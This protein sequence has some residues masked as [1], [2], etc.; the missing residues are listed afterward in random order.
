MTPGADVFFTAPTRRVKAL[1]SEVQDRPAYQHRSSVARLRAPGWRAASSEFSARD[2]GSPMA[3]RVRAQGWRVS[4]SGPS[5]CDA[6]PWLIAKVRVPPPPLSLLSPAAKTERESKPTVCVRNAASPPPSV[7]K[8]ARPAHR[9][10]KIPNSV[11]LSGWLWKASVERHPKE[12]MKIKI[13]PQSQPIDTRRREGRRDFP[14]GS[15]FI[16]Y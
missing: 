5:A 16:S 15:L 9:N 6:G 7:Q 11:T 8:L 1:A 3:A 4:S 2:A 12:P 13:R 10:L 14:T